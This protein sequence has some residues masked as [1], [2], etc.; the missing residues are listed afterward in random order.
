MRAI[1]SWEWLQLGISPTRADTIAGVLSRAARLAETADLALPQA[2]R[3][4]MAV[5]GI[6]VW[7]AA[8]TAQRALGDADAVSF[9]DYHV[10]KNIGWALTG[11]EVD[12]QGLVE[13]LAPYA[14]HR[15]RVQRLL[16][17]AGLQRPRHGARMSPRGHIPIRRSRR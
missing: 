2:R 9:G 5:P 10:A 3:R 1:P 17:L 8:E 7:T 13:V 14:P 12:D 6:G 16:A 15:Y 4:L 11:R